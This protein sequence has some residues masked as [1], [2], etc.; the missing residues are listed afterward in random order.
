MS[1]SLNLK[2]WEGLINKYFEDGSNNNAPFNQESYNNVDLSF[3][4]EEVPSGPTV[5]AHSSSL[6]GPSPSNSLSEPIVLDSTA[7][8]RR[9]LL[10]P[11]R[12]DLQSDLEEAFYG[13][14]SSCGKHQ[15]VDFVVGFETQNGRKMNSLTT[16]TFLCWSPSDLL[17]PL[18]YSLL[19]SLNLLMLVAKTT[20]TWSSNPTPMGNAQTTYLIPTLKIFVEVEKLRGSFSTGNSPTSPQNKTP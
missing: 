6:P 18:T 15:Y 3:T 19:L 11:L 16:P 1:F 4:G 7:H 20:L 17:T 12:R 10:L 8:E 9:S 14:H 2:F 5:A 13:E